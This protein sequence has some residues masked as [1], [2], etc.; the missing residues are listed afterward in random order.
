MDFRLIC[1]L[2]G[3]ETER[4]DDPPRG[5][6]ESER[7]GENL[8]DSRRLEAMMMLMMMMIGLTNER[9]SDTKS[10]RQRGA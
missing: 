4:E 8:D 10:N 2:A 5:F 1:K 7:A 3:R 9:A 6:L